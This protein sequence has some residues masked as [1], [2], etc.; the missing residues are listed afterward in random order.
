[1]IDAEGNQFYHN[2][3]SVYENH[4]RFTESS[5]HFDLKGA[6]NP[7][8]IYFFSYPHYLEGSTKVEIPL[9]E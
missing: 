2:S 9:T 6:V 3:F 4:N 5:Y 1:M 7:V 8:Q